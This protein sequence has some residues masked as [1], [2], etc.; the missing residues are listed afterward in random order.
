MIRNV[1]AYCK[2]EY[3]GDS[4]WNNVFYLE[5]TPECAN[6]ILVVVDI[7]LKKSQT[8]IPNATHYTRNPI[9][10]S[11]TRARSTPNISVSSENKT[12]TPPE[13][14]SACSGRSDAIYRSPR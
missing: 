11:A 3:H 14:T 8:P 6:P 7:C 13:P 10:P 9:L 12:S 4:G 2:P 1:T 5:H